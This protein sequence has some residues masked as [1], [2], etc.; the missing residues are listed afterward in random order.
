MR[1]LAVDALRLAGNRT[2]QGRHVE[3]LAQQWSRT[4]IP[5]DRVVLLSPR[6][7]DLSGLGTTTPIEYD[8]FGE[9]L[10]LA[11]WEQAALR[12]RARGAAGLFCPTYNAPVRYDGRLVV[13]NHGIYERLKG[14]FSTI[15]RLRA[16]PLHRLSV[17]SAD[18]V[19]ANSQQ[20]KRDMIEFFGVSDDKID[21]VYPAAAEI[22]F[23]R[24]SAAEIAAER[25]RRLG[26]DS[27]YFVFVGKL[28]RRRHVPNLIAAF[29]ELRKSRDLPHKLLI[30]GPNT[31]NT[32]VEEHASAAGVGDAVVHLDHLDQASLARLYAGSFAF[33]LPTTYEGISQTMFEAMASETAVVTVDHP[34]VHEGAGD[35]VVIAPS[36]SVR[37][38]AEA[39]R[40]LVDDPALRDDFARR[41]RAKAREFSWSRNAAETIEIL[42][43]VAA[44]R[45]GAR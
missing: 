15:A 13:M 16:T 27:P 26:D 37:D 3:Y 21:V 20:T 38:L 7:I 9:R 33:V 42:D 39:L 6:P 31:T 24:P 43:R 30:V 29:A 34:T 22:F 18:R 45:D 17:R 14:E 10:P 2:G 44:P 5:F 4:P 1:T 19:I 28:S 35:T 12:R 41:G 32:N 11:A 25:R 36:P 40:R 8:T 23:E